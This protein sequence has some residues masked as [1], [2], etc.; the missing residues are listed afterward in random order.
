MSAEDE[1]SGSAVPVLPSG[2]TTTGNQ[3]EDP[4]VNQVFT[5]F[6]D[7][8]ENKLES[9]TKEIEQKSKID[10]EVVQLKFKGNQ[11]QFELN[12]SLD[13]ILENIESE[14]QR[15]Q[16]NQE[17]IRNLAQDGRQLIRKRQKLIKI[18]D[19]SKDG[20][21]VVAEYESDELASGSEDEKRLKKAREAAGRKRRQKE[22]AA[23]DRGKKQRITGTTDNQLFRG[24]ILL[25]QMPRLLCD[26]S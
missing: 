18:A 6:K 5:L 12:A 22:Q 16:P 4:L 15:G 10:K 9:K 11:K 8:L 20:W 2:E 24:K 26:F 7:Y 1:S 21:Q 23:N 25:I 3:P 17:H 14:S 13:S 19:K